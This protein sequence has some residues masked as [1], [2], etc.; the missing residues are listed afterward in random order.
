MDRWK[1]SASKANRRRGSELDDGGDVDDGWAG[2]VERVSLRDRSEL[3]D[4]G[5]VER[6]SLRGLR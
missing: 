3:D 2:N 4:G 1:R 5:D 6:V